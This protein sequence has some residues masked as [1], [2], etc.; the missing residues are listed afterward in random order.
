MKNL[1]ASRRKLPKDKV[2]LYDKCIL[3]E[4]S[5]QCYIKFHISEQK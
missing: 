1:C 4:K 5:I 2:K 3:K